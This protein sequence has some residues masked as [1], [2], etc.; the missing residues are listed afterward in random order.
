MIYELDKIDAIRYDHKKH[1]ILYIYDIDVWD[2][3]ENDH[4]YYALKKVELYA[5]YILMGKAASY[6][7][8]DPDYSYEYSIR[9]LYN[10]KKYSNEFID[11]INELNAEI[12]KQ[13]QD[14]V[15]SSEEE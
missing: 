1:I 13:T 2:S 5:N 3:K 11:F 15:I 9:F 6:F 7:L 14:I 4:K 10:K 8:L 12:Q